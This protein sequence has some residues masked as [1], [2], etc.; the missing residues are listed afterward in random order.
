MLRAKDVREN[1]C[2]LLC[3]LRLRLE[4]GLAVSVLC[5]SL[6]YA[7][8]DPVQRECLPSFRLNLR[9]PSWL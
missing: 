2:S 4:A 1:W 9:P 6:V 5:V 3:F 7:L 8:A